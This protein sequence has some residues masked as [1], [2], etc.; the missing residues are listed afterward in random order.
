MNETEILKLLRAS[1]DAK[2]ILEYDFDFIP[3]ASLIPS[4]LFRFRDATSYEPVGGDAAGG[5][6]V[7]CESRNLP[8]RPLLYASSEGQAGI[9]AQSLHDGLSII[10][11][12]PYWQDCLKFSS[13]GQLAEMQRVVPL[14]ESDLLADRPQTASRRQALR[15]L[16]GLS[17]LPDPVCALHTA[18]TDLSPQY[19]VCSSE[20][21]PF[22]PLFN[23]FT[24]KSN[25]EWRRRLEL[26]A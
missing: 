16:L 14:A 2:R 25:P 8:T 4:R 5:E 17:Q 24:V 21:W 18:V 15:T 12:L 1:S 11:D 22:E 7:L 6:F 19:A 20:G 3:V 23:K 10:V 26:Q 13:H 9:I